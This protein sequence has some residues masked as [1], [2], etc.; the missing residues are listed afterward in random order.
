[1][2]PLYGLS[3]NAPEWAVVDSPAAGTWWVYIEG[4]EMYLQDYY[5]LYLTLE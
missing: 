2:D 5:R 3:G 1:V 4:Y